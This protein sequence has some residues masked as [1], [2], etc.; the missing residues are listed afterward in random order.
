MLSP[1]RCQPHNGSMATKQYVMTVMA[2]NR[3]GILAALAT[4]LDELGGG[5]V[6]LS[7]A[8]M[9]DY[10]TIIMA[11]EFPADR[12]TEVIVDH[13]RAV[14][15]PFGMDVLLRDPANE[16]AIES[17]DDAPDTHAYLLRVQGKDRPGVLRRIAL[18]LAQEGI[19]IIDLYG[20]RNDQTATF[21]SSLALQVPAGVDVTRLRTDLDHLLGGSGNVSVSIF[22][23]DLF[24]AITEPQPPAQLLRSRA[25][26][27]R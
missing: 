22:R 2:A 19:D 12:P 8:I 13:L 27:L 18:R 24:A 17:R 14:G 21:D 1:S 20:E 11:V 25:G 9:R 16:P 7:Q 23:C 5:F 6:D 26:A 10:F 3:V 15:R 4:A